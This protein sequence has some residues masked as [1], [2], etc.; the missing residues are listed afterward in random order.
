VAALKPP[1]PMEN[2]LNLLGQDVIFVVLDVETTG[3]DDKSCH[4]I[5]LAAKVLGSEDDEDLFSEYILPPIERI[6]EKIEELTGITDDFLRHGG[7]DPA[8]GKERGTAR[9]FRP[10]FLDFQEFCRE[11]SNGKELVFVAHNS[12]FD[13]KMINGEL[14][15][16]RLSE[17]ETTAPT[18]GD[19]FSS[20]LDTLHLFRQGK[21][22][23]SNV[24]RTSPRRPSSFSLSSLHLHVLN[25][26]IEDS[27]NAVG[28]I[29]A[30][31]RVLLSE[32]FIGWES[33]AN[34]IQVPFIKVDLT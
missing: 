17:H 5:Q 14:R 6:P 20:S 21:W 31:E 30:L 26:S 11:R 7:Y 13:I 12:K 22:W 32:P 24:E 23:R 10:V 2:R 25:E 15:R 1:V 16:W 27:H 8:L 28:D 29:K 19:I 9:D 4:I 34:R 33:T 18:L 3:L